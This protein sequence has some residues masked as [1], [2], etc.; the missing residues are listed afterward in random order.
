V[1]CPFTGKV[2]EPFDNRTGGLPRLW[3]IVDERGEDF[4]LRRRR[5]FPFRQHVIYQIVETGQFLIFHTDDAPPG[6]YQG[7]HW[8]RDN[9]ACW[10]RH[11]CPNL[12]AA[13]K[14]SARWQRAHRIQRE[15]LQAE[16]MQ[17]G[18]EQ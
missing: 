9:G 4:T 11:C 5:H 15:R 2:N 13:L 3:L 14:L 1:R 8:G 12:K 16:F 7:V 18:V 6:P 10:A 17:K